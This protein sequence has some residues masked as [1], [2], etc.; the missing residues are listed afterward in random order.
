[1]PHRD[2]LYAWPDGEFFVLVVY[3]QLYEC[4]CA[5]TLI[6]G[7]CG[8]LDRVCAK[9]NIRPFE[10]V[11]ASI[12][13]LLMG[14]FTFMPL[15]EFRCNAAVFAL[16]LYLLLQA[17]NR[18]NRRVGGTPAWWALFAAAVLPIVFMVVSAL[19]ELNR[20]NYASINL[21]GIALR[22]AQALICI[23]ALFNERLKLALRHKRRVA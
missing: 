2:M 8:M 12:I 17:T 16:P 20:M 18:Q 23:A 15:A 5:C 21:S 7:V 1:M 13:P 14:R 22:N 4:L 19:V 11:F 10:L 9:L 6:L 3:M